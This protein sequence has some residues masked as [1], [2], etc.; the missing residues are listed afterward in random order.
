MKNKNLDSILKLCEIVREKS[1]P[2]AENLNFLDFQQSLTQAIEYTKDQG[3]GRPLVISLI[4]GTGTGKSLIFSKICQ[5]EDASPSSDAIRGFTQKLHVAACESDRPF[6]SFKDETVF[7]P[8]IM[9]GVVLIDTPDLDSIHR[10]NALLT[11]RIIQDSDFLVYV[12]TPDKRS[13]FDIQQTILNWASRK[14]WFF[15]MNKT[16]TFGE[17]DLSSLKKDF[18][19]KITTLG[20]KTNDKHVFLFSARDENSFEFSRFKDAIFSKRSL[21]QNCLIRETASIR[22]ILHV[23]HENDSFKNIRNLYLKLQNQIDLLKDRLANIPGEVLK[24]R[25]VDELADQVR[26]Q[27]VY[28]HLIQGRTFFLFPWF[29]AFSKLN[30]VVSI[31]EISSRIAFG[32]KETGNFND[33]RKDEERILID[34]DLPAKHSRQEN[35]AYEIELSQQIRKNLADSAGEISNN[36]L[37]AFYLFLG[38]LLPMIIA[39]QALF[40]IFSQWL[41][42]MWLPSDFF[43]HAAMIIAGSTLPGYLLV[44]KGIKRIASTRSLA[45]L[46]IAINTE[47][48]ES[49]KISLED[50]LKDSQKLMLECE[51]R[52]KICESSLEAENGAIVSSIEEEVG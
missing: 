50:F 19:E 4:G 1:A 26:N 44:S 41:A 21:Q 7:V 37:I 52:L 29:W 49:I 34:L 47:N 16:D 39:L 46:S 18:L 5:K 28:Q 20:F 48:L 11:Q 13:N 2:F 17:N 24:S 30:P 9:E 23:M 25:S 40:R 35:V 8:G 51:K 31:N 12:T 45:D 6:L 10:Q 15:V 38:N 36:R 14:R 22:Q 43:L 33:C 27:Q 3:I 32:I 42:G